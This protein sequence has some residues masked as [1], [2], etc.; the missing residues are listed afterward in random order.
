MVL[1]NDWFW[2]EWGKSAVLGVKKSA[3]FKCKGT[4]TILLL[5]FDDFFRKSMMTIFFSY[6]DN[7]DA[8]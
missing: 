1:K 4:F 2:T 7:I 5:I 8:F 3:F 6:L